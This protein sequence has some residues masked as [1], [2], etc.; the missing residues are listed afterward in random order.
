MKIV[1]LEDEPM[2]AMD[3]ASDIHSLRPDWQVI[4]TLGSVKQATEWLAANG[5]FDLIFSDIQLGDGTC[6]DVF[7]KVAPTAPVIFCTA[8]D[9]Y[10][11]Q[12]FQANGIGY[13]LKPYSRDSLRLAIEK[14]EK[15]R[16]L[17]LIFRRFWHNLFRPNPPFRAHTAS[18][19]TT[20]T[21]SFRCPW[22]RLRC[23]TCTMKIQ[24]CCASTGNV[25]VEESEGR[26]T[27]GNRR[28]LLP[29][30]PTALGDCKRSAEATRYFARKL[31]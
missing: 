4:Q 23:F 28:L 26:A 7:S 31:L 18:W 16:P 20:K 22:R 13:L 25:C 9:Q 29:R 27:S 2:M 19:C 12:A 10:A 24:C 30:K 3:L 17:R 6:F 1:I 15:L 11:L 5:G 8:Y 21:R 14:F